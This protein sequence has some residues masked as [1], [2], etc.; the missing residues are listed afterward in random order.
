MKHLWKDEEQAA[1]SN[2]RQVHFDQMEEPSWRFI[3]SSPTSIVNGSEEILFEVMF[4]WSTLRRQ[5]LRY[6]N[7]CSDSRTKLFMTAPED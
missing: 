2:M 4:V 6:M 5:F 3:L 1:L 7:S